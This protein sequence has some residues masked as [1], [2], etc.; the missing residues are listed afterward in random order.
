MS[1]K[2]YLSRKRVIKKAFSEDTTWKFYVSRG[3]FYPCL[4]SI[5]F[6]FLILCIIFK[7]SNYQLGQNK[8]LLN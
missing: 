5:I 1:K 6:V 2:N 4:F 3:L 7:F 8:C